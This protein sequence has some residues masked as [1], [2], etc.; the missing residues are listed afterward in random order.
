MRK[1]AEHVR[2]AAFQ[3]IEAYYN[4]SRI[5]RRIGYMSPAKYE[6]RFD[7]EKPVVT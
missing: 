1:N 6:S 2:S 4:R 7:K 5:Q 3:F